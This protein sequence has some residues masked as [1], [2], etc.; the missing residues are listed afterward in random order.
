[1]RKGKADYGMLFYGL[2]QI[3]RLTNFYGGEAT[4]MYHGISYTSPLLLDWEE[5]LP[6]W[7]ISRRV[8]YKELIVQSRKLST[9]PSM[10][11]VLQSM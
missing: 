7:K 8:L 11:E 10:Q 3:E 5:L 1:M 4:V 9:S 2:Q 6:E